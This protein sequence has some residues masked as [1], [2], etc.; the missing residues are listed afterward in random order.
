VRIIHHFVYLSINAFV[1]ITS[2]WDN[3]ISMATYHEH[4]NEHQHEPTPPKAKG[5]RRAGSISLVKG[6]AFGALALFTKNPPLA[7][8]SGH[9][10]GDK[11]AFSDEAHASE[12]HD[13]YERATLMRRAANKILWLTIAAGGAELMLEAFSPVGH[14]DLLGLAGNAL[15]Q[16]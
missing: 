10:I 7:V 6:F 1:Y 8:I 12:S 3:R 2:F 5:L 4:S 13:P 11:L 16:T 15:R 14:N 9:D